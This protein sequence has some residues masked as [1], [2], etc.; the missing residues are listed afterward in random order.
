MTD[1]IACKDCGALILPST[2]E[3][4]GG[5]CLPCKGNYRKNIEE[6]RR[7]HEEKKKFENSPERKHWEWLVTKVYKTPEG[8]TA[9]SRQNQ[10]YF[11]ANIL[12]GEVYNGGFDQYFT[13]SSGNFYFDSLQA[14]ESMGAFNTL[15]LLLKAK[16]ILF[17]NTEVPTDRAERLS[18]MRTLAP[19]EEATDEKFAQLNIIDKELCGDPDNFDRLLSSFANKNSLYEN[20]I[21]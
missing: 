8:Y 7:R 21:T 17:G 15:N 1:K 6:S 18:V 14:L 5:F 12:V 4:T 9:L 3:R 11:A 2:A 13:N 20:H 10:L 19:T 16:E